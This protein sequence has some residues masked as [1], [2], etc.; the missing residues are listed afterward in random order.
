MNYIFLIQVAA[1]QLLLQS[2]NVSQGTVYKKHKWELS[3]QKVLSSA[4]QLTNVGRWKTHI[5]Y[6]N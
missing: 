3:I 4:E 5:N 6:R 2:E 1:I